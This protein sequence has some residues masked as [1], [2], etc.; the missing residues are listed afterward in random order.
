MATNGPPKADAS[1]PPVTDA[2]PAAASS[3]A[4]DLVMQISRVK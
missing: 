3:A 1:S 4:L 2:T